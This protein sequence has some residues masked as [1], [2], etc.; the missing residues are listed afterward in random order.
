MLCINYIYRSYHKYPLFQISTTH[1]ES[2]EITA[3]LK[4]D[5]SEKEG[6][7]KGIKSEMNHINGQ[8]SQSHE[9]VSR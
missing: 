9:K 8:L 5:L 7:I 3:Q 4:S 1:K 6:T 2:S